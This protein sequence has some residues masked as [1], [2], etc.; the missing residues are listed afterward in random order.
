MAAPIANQRSQSVLFQLLDQLDKPD[1]E[2]LRQ[3]D[4]VDD[5]DLADPLVQ[6]ELVDAVGASNFT[7]HFG[8][9]RRVGADRESRSHLP[10]RRRD[11]G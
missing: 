7:M 8:D 6:M 9:L 10:E 4:A 3:F 2:M 1:R 5:R 11:D